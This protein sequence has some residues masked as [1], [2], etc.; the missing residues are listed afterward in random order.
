MAGERKKHV[1][2]VCL[3]KVLFEVISDPVNRSQKVRN[4]LSEVLPDLE[5]TERLIPKDFTIGTKPFGGTN[6]TGSGT[7][8]KKERKKSSG[9]SDN[10]NICLTVNLDRTTVEKMRNIKAFL[11]FSEAMRF[12]ITYYLLKKNAE[13]G[14][15]D[16]NGK[17]DS[18]GETDILGDNYI[19]IGSKIFRIIKK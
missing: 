2:T 7:E 4:I 3:P 8:N 19:R 18:A 12:C 14:T 15:D 13:N 6:L 16:E 17:E 5:K 1:I 9:N 11:S 10:N